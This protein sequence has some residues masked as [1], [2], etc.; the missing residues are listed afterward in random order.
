M[1]T[2]LQLII[3]LCVFLPNNFYS[4]NIK[5]K[6]LTTN[7]WSGLDYRGTFRFGEYENDEIRERRFEVLVKQ[8]KQYDLDIIFTQESNPVGKYASRLADELDFDEIHQVCNAG[9]KFGPVG[10]PTNFK[11]GLVILARK[12]LMFHSTLL[13]KDFF[14]LPHCQWRA[15]DEFY[16]NQ[17][18]QR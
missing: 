4:Q 12:N 9:I 1:K 2:I 10:I 6:V 14:F 17:C 5:L 13:P 15:K 18:L 7:V 16:P 3:L 8:I 11:E